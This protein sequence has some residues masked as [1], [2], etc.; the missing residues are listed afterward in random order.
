[1]GARPSDGWS[2]DRGLYS[3]AGTGERR[4]WCDEWAVWWR[5]RINGLEQSEGESEGANV[6]AS[7]V[8][9]M[10]HKR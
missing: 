1:M 2:S 9:A 4:L 3:R 10:K 5:V 7:L 6:F 8:C